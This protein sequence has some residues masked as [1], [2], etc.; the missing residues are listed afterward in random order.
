MLRFVVFVVAISTVFAGTLAYGGMRMGAWDEA[1]PVPPSN[2]A[3]L[4][5]PDDKN[6]KDKGAKKKG[7]GSAAGQASSQKARWVREA[8]A[9]CRRASRETGRL[10]WPSTVDRAEALFERMA[11]MYARY[12]AAFASLDPAKADRVK[13][14]RVHSLFDRDEA[15]MAEWLRTLSGGRST[16]RPVL[17]MMNRL[18]DSADK[19]NALL[20]GAGA[21]DCAAGFYVPSA[22]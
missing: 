12:D 19:R 18:S 22:F 9:L 11:A 4:T 8:N 2:Q 6:K 16:P 13:L 20:A 14:G 7:S 5:R 21:A 1:D 15:L 17:D 3:P 10:N